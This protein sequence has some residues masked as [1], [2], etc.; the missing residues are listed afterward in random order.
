MTEASL[1]ILLAE[2]ADPFTA[3]LF[4][5]AARHKISDW[6]ALTRFVADYRVMPPGS[7]PLTSKIVTAAEIAVPVSLLF[8]EWRQYGAILAIG[9]LTV[10]AAA[11]ALNL[12]RGRTYIDCGCGGAT[13]PLA[14]SLVARNAILSGIAALVLL[15]N[16]NAPPLSAVFIGIAVGLMTWAAY[17]TVEQVLHNQA[18]IRV[19][20]GAP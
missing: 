11:I 10:Y 15:S 17:V 9:L 4:A 16:G 8:R 14:W 19:I 20:V 6:D 7:V 18:R 12:L 5:N 1:N 3:L 2:A 13:R